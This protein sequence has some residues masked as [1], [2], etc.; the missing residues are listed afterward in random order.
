MFD[1]KSVTNFSDLLNKKYM[2]IVTVLTYAVHGRISTLY[3][4][5]HTALLNITDRRNM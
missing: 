5:M 2:H 1:F 4:S 3:S